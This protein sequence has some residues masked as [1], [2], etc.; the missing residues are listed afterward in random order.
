ML[1]DGCS[2]ECETTFRVQYRNPSASGK[3]VVVPS[4]VSC[5][6]CAR[7]HDFPAEVIAIEY[8]TLDGEWRPAS[9]AKHLLANRPNASLEALPDKG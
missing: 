8:L 1:F 6:C 7:Q 4:S 2:C 5:P 9:L 3:D